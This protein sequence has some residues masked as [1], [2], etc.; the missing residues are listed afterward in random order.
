MAAYCREHGISQPSFFAWKRRL[1]DSAATPPFV[2]V[3]VAA[4]ERAVGPAMEVC[5]AGRHIL[6]LRG[7][8]HDLLIELVQTLERLPAPS[9]SRLS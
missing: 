7:F 1:R 6:V 3:K 2:E 5:L 9:L 4:G 8:D